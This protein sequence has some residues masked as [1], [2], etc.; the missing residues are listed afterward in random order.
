MAQDQR[1]YVNCN[2]LSSQLAIIFAL[3]VG[4]Q[5]TQRMLGLK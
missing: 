4:F 1:T 2:L 5:W 3:M